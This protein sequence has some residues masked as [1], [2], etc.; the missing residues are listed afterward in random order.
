MYVCIA[1]GSGSVLVVGNIFTHATP[2]TW[3]YERKHETY[4]VAAPSEPP[5]RLV[6]QPFMQ[7][8]LPPA[9]ARAYDTIPANPAIP[10]ATLGGHRAGLH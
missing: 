4:H 10:A 3:E 7:E 6:M 9:V 8:A 5:K 1:D 2:G